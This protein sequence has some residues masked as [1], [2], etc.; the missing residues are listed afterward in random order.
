MRLKKGFCSVIILCLYC[1]TALAQES[2]FT[3]QYAN[4]LSLNPAFAG[5]N[6]NWS[7]SLSH[8]NQWPALNGSFITNQFTADYR[9]GNSKSAINLAVQQDRAGI[10]GLQKL[11]ATAGYAHHTALTEKWAIAAGLQVSIAS[12]RVNFDNLVFGDQLS[13]NGQIAVTSAEAAKFEPNSYLSFTV[14]GLVYSDQFWVGLKVANLNKPAYGFENETRLPIGYVVNTGYK[15]YARSYV[16]QGRL[17]E[18][19]FTPSAT[20]IHQNN[21]NRADFGLHTI[22]TPLTLGIIYKGI[23]VTSGTNQ[24]QALS[25]IAGLQIETLKIGFSHDIGLSGISRQAGGANEISLVFE[26]LEIDKLFGSRSGRKINRR[27][28][29]PAF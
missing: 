23:P 25:V 17:F 24:D 8:R 19:S 13:D 6:H 21:F 16:E 10:G 29:C 15:F 5:L 14:G 27:I 20:Y 12:L 1:L 11:Q 22:Y 28:P 26:Q 3:Q 2:H 9:L 7:A 4:R 18:L